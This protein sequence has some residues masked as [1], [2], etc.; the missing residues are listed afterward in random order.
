MAQT[1]DISAILAALAQRP[2]ATPNP[3]M[4]APAPAP[5]PIQNHQQPPLPAGYPGVVSAATPSNPLAGMSLPQPMASGGLD[6]SSIK[7]I[8]SGNVSLA[9]AIAKAQTNPGS[10]DRRGSRRSRSRSPR[11]DQYGDHSYNPF[12]DERRDDARRGGS[13]RRERSASPPRAGNGYILGVPASEMMDE[14]TEVIQVENSSVGLIIGRQGEN[15]KRVEQA[16]G[17]RVQFMSDDKTSLFRKCKITGNQRQRADA[18]ADIYKTVEENPKRNANANANYGVQ[19]RSQDQRGD[20]NIQPPLKEGERSTQILVP[21]KTVGLIIGRR[22]ETITDLQERSGC[23]INILGEN[24]SSGGY[25]PINLIGTPEAAAK[26]QQLINEVVDSDTRAPNSSSAHPQMQSPYGA[27]PPQQYG[28]YDPYAS[29]SGYGAPDPHAKISEQIHIPSEA[30]GMVIG[31]GG[32][33]I[34]EMQSTHSCKIN[35]SQPAGPDIT[36]QI[37]LI[38]SRSAIEGAKT[39]IYQKVQTVVR[40]ISILRYLVFA[41]LFFYSVKSKEPCVLTLCLI[42]MHMTRMLNIDHNLRMDILPQTLL[43]TKLWPPCLRLTHTPLMV[44]MLLM[45]LCG[46]RVLATKAVRLLDSKRVT[47]RMRAVFRFMDMIPS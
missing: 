41:N 42:N 12:R 34:K 17:A 6:L 9:D 19:S 46:S 3:T 33:T 25:R 47:L 32:E 24:K 13:P 44:A 36:R 21:D 16:S 45:L 39:A 18:I 29:S 11:R 1:P 23:H 26:A 7:P 8:S 35:V 37:D 2:A 40:I 20:A 22:G 27:A 14:K 31:K 10:G 28:A 15:L 30:V 43:H 4:P 5:L 38:G